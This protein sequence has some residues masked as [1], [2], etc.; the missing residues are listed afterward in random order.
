MIRFL[1]QYFSKVF[2]G[3]L[4]AKKIWLFYARPEA[5]L[6]EAGERR[7]AETIL[8]S[9]ERNTRAGDLALLY[10]ISLDRIKLDEMVSHLG[11]TKDLAMRIKGSDLGKDIPLI[12][13]VTSVRRRFLPCWWPWAAGCEVERVHWFE[14]AITLAE[15]KQSS[16]LRRSWHDLNRNFRATGRSALEIPAEA[17]RHLSEFLK[18]RGF[19]GPRDFNNNS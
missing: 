13:K 9:C 1:S 10:R 11:M 16:Q 18:A 7:F 19:S 6:D 5:W 2:D 4:K 12:W 14:R 8:W 15:L 17:W 3:G